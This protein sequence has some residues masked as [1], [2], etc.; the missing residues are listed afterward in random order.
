[1]KKEK[2]RKVLRLVLQTEMTNHAIAR[3]ECCSANTVKKCRR[4]AQLNQW[5][6]GVLQELDDQ[7]IS[8]Y[9][10]VKRHFQKN[11]I[12]PDWSEIHKLMQKKHQTLI[13]LWEEYR[14]T[15][16]AQ[17]YSY[18]Q[19]T[20]YYRQHLSKV[21]ICMRQVH[22]AGDI[23]FV[24]YA[25]KTIEWMDLQLNK[26]RKAQIFVATLGCS[27]YTFA[28]ASESQKLKDWINAHIQMFKFFGGV[29]NVIVPDNLKSAVT[30][31]GSLSE[32]NKTYQELAEHY[33]C[34]IIPSR[35]RRPQDK[36]KAELSV[37]FITRWITVPLSRRQFFSIEE[38]NEAIAECL[39]SFNQRPFKNLPGCRLGRF[40]ELDKPA[41]SPLPEEPYEYAQ[42]MAPQKVASDYHIYV[43]GHAYSVPYRL[44]GE[45]VEARVSLASVEI[46]H[47]HKRVACHPLSTVQGEATTNPDHRPTR[48]LQYANQS[49]EYF[50][51]WAYH[52]GNEVVQVVQAQFHGRADYSMVGKKACSQLKSLAKTYGESRLRA[53]CARALK[54]SSPTVKSIRSILQH[55]LDEQDT[56]QLHSSGHVPDHQNV[57]GAEYYLIGGNDHAS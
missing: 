45:R 56:H 44:V 29:P 8:Q 17:A 19:F 54:F 33:G 7:Q 43:Q 10:L 47:L 28:W 35:V 50:L 25:G 13:Q 31:P 12:D 24:D 4:I 49:M 41:L 5:T 55:H 30:K 16:G 53:A 11:K 48:H 52:I 40:E 37:K 18:S 42:W 38:I 57:R 26:K 36:S 14:D 46:F 32:I 22:F 2:Y 6:W 15:W 23:V 21:D 9:F 20:H 1:M 27:N 34:V 3:L 39:V 51:D